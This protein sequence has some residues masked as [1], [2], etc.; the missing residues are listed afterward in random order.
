MWGCRLKP[1]VQPC[2]IAR[3]LSVRSDLS[4]EKVN[5]FRDHG[6]GRCWEKRSF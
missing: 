2:I 4:S 1:V 3:H 6:V 5:W